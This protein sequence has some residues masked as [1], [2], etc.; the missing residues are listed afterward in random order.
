MMYNLTR[1]Q[2]LQCS[3]LCRLFGLRKNDVRPANLATEV[4]IS[5]H[6][7]YQYTGSNITYLFHLTSES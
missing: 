3:V 4:L 2:F 5:Y 6:V 7:P 1:K